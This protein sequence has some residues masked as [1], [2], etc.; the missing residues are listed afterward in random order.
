MKRLLL[1]ALLLGT[2]AIAGPSDD[3]SWPCIQRKQP[4]LSIGQ[5]WP[6]PL[7]DDSAAELAQ[8]PDIAAL[9]Q[10]LEQRR[11]SL[12]EAEAEI[13]AF[14][15]RA[16]AEELTALFV[17]VFDRINAYRS[18]IMSGVARYAEKQVTL[19]AQI[20]A[21]R[22][23]L[24]RLSAAPEPDF[25]KLDAEEARLDWDVRIFTD[26]QSQL[27]YVCETP[28]ILEQRAFA[29]GRA[30]AAHLPATPIPAP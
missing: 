17:A 12:P 27:T 3:P 19:S 10:V 9:A 2:P 29:L 25:D 14:A 8:R 4:H 28:V 11:L 15:E 22:A 6:G 1:A 18:R 23:E 5:L 13:A 7:P 24:T 16:S 30:I 26:R 20:E 21:R